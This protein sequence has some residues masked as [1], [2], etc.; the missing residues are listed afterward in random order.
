[1]EW[2]LDILESWGPGYRYLMTQPAKWDGREPKTLTLDEYEEYVKSNPGGAFSIH[3]PR[4]IK[5]EWGPPKK[6]RLWN[7][8]TLP[9]TKYQ[10]EH[11]YEPNGLLEVI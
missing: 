10:R 7:I 4:V 8:I 3:S 1:M 5:E 6:V 2:T 9:P 11:Y